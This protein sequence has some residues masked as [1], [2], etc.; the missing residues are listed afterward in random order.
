VI[1]DDTKPVQRGVEE[2][3]SKSSTVPDMR[4]LA[5]QPPVFGCIG[6]STPVMKY[7][8]TE[9]FVLSACAQFVAPIH[10]G[11][12]AVEVSNSAPVIAIRLRMPLAY[13]HL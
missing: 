2:A 9:L 11:F 3:D 7:L 12:V 5:R 8:S 13:P 1:F 6:S 4:L 10:R